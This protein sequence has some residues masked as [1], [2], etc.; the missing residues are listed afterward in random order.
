ME[1]KKLRQDIVVM[2]NEG[3]D[4]IEEGVLKDIIKDAS[5]VNIT[6]HLVKLLSRNY[7]ISLS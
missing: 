2:R 4:L 1:E 6:G 3:Y 7:F 5:L